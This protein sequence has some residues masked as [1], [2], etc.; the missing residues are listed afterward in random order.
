[1]GILGCCAAIL[2]P[3]LYC[4]SGDGQKRDISKIST[5]DFNSSIVYPPLDMGDYGNE[6]D[7]YLALTSRFTENNKNKTVLDFSD[8]IECVWTNF[9]WTGDDSALYNRLTATLN[10]IADETSQKYTGTFGPLN[11]AFLNDP[12][13]INSESFKT[14]LT[15]YFT[16][17]PTQEQLINYF[18]EQN[19]F[20]TWDDQYWTFSI[21]QFIYPYENQ[22]EAQLD[23]IG[24]SPQ[25]LFEGS[26]YL[27]F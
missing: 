23:L 2:L 8:G 26:L 10:I 27:S 5:R 13:I 3:L 24:M 16:S 14:D 12:E 20:I 9:Q 15:H 11:V 7:Q 18:K 21:T 19:T 4:T 22:G 17:E 25:F 1:M 6:E